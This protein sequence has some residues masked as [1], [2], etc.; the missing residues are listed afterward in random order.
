MKKKGFTLIEAVV[1][2]WV[3]AIL[4]AIAMPTFTEP[5]IVV[6]INQKSEEKTLVYKV[7]NRY[8]YKKLYFQDV[9]FDG[10]L[11]SVED[12]DGVISDPNTI[13]VRSRSAPA[14]RV[15]SWK[16]WVD[17]FEQKIRPEAVRN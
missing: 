4:V 5:K 12:S 9:G 2:I 11:N 13:T 14:A 10:N 16:I 1:V 8:D 15:V 3:V 17:R 7:P 6:Y